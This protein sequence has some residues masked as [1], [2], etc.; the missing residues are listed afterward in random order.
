[1]RLILVAVGRAGRLLEPAMA[2]YLERAGRYWSLEVTEVREE[3]AGRGRSEEDVRNA[4]AERILK[5]APRD[6]D[7][8]AITRTGAAWSSTR[9]ADHMRRHVLEAGR[10]ETYVIGGA[11][12]LG[13]AV[14]GA[15]HREMSLSALTM[16]HDLA[17][18]VLLEQLYRAGTILRGEP[19]HK[20]SDAL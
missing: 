15:A 1:M 7:I 13:A 11:F 9:L 4:E 5:R 18:L 2:D 12:G 19:Y 14:L 16:P 6:S 8:V 20:G 17:R 10:P 3:R